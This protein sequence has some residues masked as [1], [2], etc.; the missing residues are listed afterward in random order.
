MSR[1]NPAADVFAR[2]ADVDPDW[3]IFCRGHDR[4]DSTAPWVA[5]SAAPDRRPVQQAVRA[6]DVFAQSDRGPTP[7]APE[8]EEASA[9]PDRDGPAPT[10]RHL[11]SRIVGVAYPN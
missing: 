2:R 9:V 8:T 6:L 7:L 1:D 5:P 3:E 11:D 4:D 10:V